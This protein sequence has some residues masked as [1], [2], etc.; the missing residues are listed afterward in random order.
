M[1]EEADGKTSIQ[2]NNRSITE[3]AQ[4][5]EASSLGE[6]AVGSHRVFP[7]RGRT[8]RI[9]DGLSRAPNSASGSATSR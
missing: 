9:S 8:R 7:G 5:K 4:R 1:G 6:H 3:A 2:L